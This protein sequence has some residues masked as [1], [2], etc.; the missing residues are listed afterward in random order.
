VKT[1]FPDYKERRNG[2]ELIINNPFDN[3]TGYHFNINN[4]KGVCHDW[5]SNNWATINPRTGHHSTTFLNF[6]R[7]YRKCSWQQALKEVM[8]AHTYAIIKRK[9]EPEER[10]EQ[11]SLPNGSMSIIGSSESLMSKV[12]TNWLKSRGVTVKQIAEYNIHH[13]ASDVVWP[14]YEYNVLVYWQ[15]RSILSKRF[16][17]PAK[18]VADKNYFYGFDSV[19]LASYVI[20]TEAI[21]GVLTLGS[22]TL[23]SGGALMSEKLVHKL[24]L[25]DPIDGIILAPDNDK[26]GIASLASNS[27][28]LQHMK[29]KVYYSLP[30]KI[31]IGVDEKGKDRFTKDWNDLIKMMDK[32]EILDHLQKGIRPCNKFELV[33]LMIGR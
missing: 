28:L 1:H 31:K 7:L 8:G 11:I 22:Q 25:L 3:D 26:A 5:R 29:Y 12:V 14:Y 10:I 4:I 20:I 16:T 13:L 6:V 33:K 24:K 17:F 32:K 23:A 2:E 21:F 15:T 27:L 19:E 18:N 9:S 30:P